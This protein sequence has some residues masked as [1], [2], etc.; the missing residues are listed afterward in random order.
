[1]DKEHQDKR[2]YQQQTKAKVESNSN[3]IVEKFRKETKLVNNFIKYCVFNLCT[4]SN[5]LNKR[6]NSI[7]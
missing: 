2:C 1:M 5:V 6:F 4:M 3:D 7:E